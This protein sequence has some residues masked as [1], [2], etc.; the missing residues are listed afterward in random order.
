MTPWID[1]HNHLHQIAGSEAVTDLAGLA[2]PVLCVVNGTRE[3]DWQE[4]VDFVGLHPGM[5]MA[6]GWHPWF[7]HEQTQGWETRLREILL[8]FPEASLGEIGVDAW[9]Q[10]TPNLKEQRTVLRTQLRLAADLDRPVTVHGLK[11]WQALLEIL[12][13]TQPGPPATLVHAFGG[14][15]EMVPHL[16][17]LN[18]WVSFNPYFLHSRKSAQLATFDAVPL[19]RLL[20]ETDAPSMGPPVELAEWT[21]PGGRTGHPANVALA[22][23]AMATRRGIPEVEFVEIIAGN[24]ARC[25]GQARD[26]QAGS[27]PS[28]ISSSAPAASNPNTPVT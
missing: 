3:S 10:G 19:E 1:A 7:L 6:F 16:V 25:F 20:I 12:I 4:V 14:P 5:R 18:G 27:S 8:R 9:K 22:Y 28:I 2:R 15:V 26:S 17:R 21:L 24:F 11:A 23:R 13:E